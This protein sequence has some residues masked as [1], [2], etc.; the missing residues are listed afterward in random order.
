[1]LAVGRAGAAA[2][3]TSVR[4]SYVL[5]NGNLRVSTVEAKAAGGSLAGNFA[6]DNLSGNTVSR[7]ALAISNASLLAV[8][9]IA[10]TAPFVQHPVVGQ[11]DVQAQAGWAGSFSNCKGHAHAT[12]RAP[13]E[14]AASGNIPLSGEIEVDYDRPRGWRRLGIRIWRCG[15]PELR[16]TA[17]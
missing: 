11:M 15:R 10:G 1:M 9:Q 8:S 13:S 2:E 16:S 3:L 17:R 12:V 14:A 4:G 5:A 7:M 6:M